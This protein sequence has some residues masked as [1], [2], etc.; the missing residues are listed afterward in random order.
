MAMKKDERKAGYVK[1]MKLMI[2]GEHK[3]A[4]DDLAA[5]CGEDTGLFWLVDYD[6]AVKA[7]ADK[8]A[9]DAQQGNAA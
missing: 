4:F 5:M 6:E 8:K 7:L 1:V 9:A 3:A 2:Q